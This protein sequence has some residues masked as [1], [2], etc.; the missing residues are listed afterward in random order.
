[1]AIG[2][3]AKAYFIAGVSLADARRVFRKGGKKTEP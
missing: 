2:G 1:M 3:A